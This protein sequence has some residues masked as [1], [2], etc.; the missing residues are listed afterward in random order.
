M[1]STRIPPVRIGSLIVSIE[2]EGSDNKGGDDDLHDISSWAM[3]TFDGA[4]R[5]ITLVARD[6]G[7]IVA[8]LRA[9]CDED[10]LEIDKIWV[11][12]SY[13]RQGIASKLLQIAMRSS[14]IKTAYAP[15]LTSDGEAWMDSLTTEVE[16]DGEMVDRYVFPA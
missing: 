16:M 14:G 4:N 3:N 9:G 13:R 8:A 2:I 11:E 7:E 6:R 12:G 15:H 1:E 10:P 5:I